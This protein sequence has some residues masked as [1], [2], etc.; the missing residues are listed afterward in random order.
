M[1][2]VFVIPKDY[3][4]SEKLADRIKLCLETLQVGVDHLTA[5]TSGGPTATPKGF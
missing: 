1:A 3:D 4:A 2:I 5:P